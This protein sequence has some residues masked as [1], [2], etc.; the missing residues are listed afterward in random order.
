MF[1]RNQIAL[2]N[3]SVPEG[4]G[5]FFQPYG[6]PVSVEGLVIYTRYEVGGMT[7]G[8]YE[9]RMARPYTEE[10]P[11]NK[12]EVLDVV[13]EI[14]KPAINYLQYKKVLRLIRTHVDT[15]DKCYGNSTDW[16]IEYI[17]FSEL[18]RLIC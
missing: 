8:H 2:I 6:I 9:G 15:E 5:V 1:T 4:Q 7:G 14:I 18:I 3:K 16:K 10:P 17:V 12:F 13:L 11:E